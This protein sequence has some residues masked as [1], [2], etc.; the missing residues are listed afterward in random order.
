MEMNRADAEQAHDGANG[1]F[2]VGSLPQEPRR[3]LRERKAIPERLV[4][5]AV[6][7][8]GQV[9]TIGLRDRDHRTR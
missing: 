1:F 6:Q 3:R 5:A 2:D 4:E 9:E 7:D 8:L